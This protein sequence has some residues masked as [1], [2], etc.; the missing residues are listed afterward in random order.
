MVKR[1][2]SGRVGAFCSGSP[3]DSWKTV[4]HYRFQK[5]GKRAHWSVHEG[6]HADDTPPNGRICVL[7]VPTNFLNE[8]IDLLVDTPIQSLEYLSPGAE[9]ERI[10][11]S[12]DYPVE[13]REGLTEPLPERG[14]IVPDQRNGG[15]AIGE[16][17][18]D[19]G[20]DGSSRRPGRL[21]ETRLNVAAK[22]IE[23]GC[24]ES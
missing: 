1:H 5:W 9:G 12:L 18:A 16:N 6:M 17:S 22:E 10:P 23:A 14:F 24:A 21:N 4:G 20:K 11:P 15:T 8:G 2:S 19:V 3:P 7:K 13:P